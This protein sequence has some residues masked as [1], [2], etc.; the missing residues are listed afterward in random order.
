ME[1]GDKTRTDCTVVQVT[2]HAP[3]DSSLLW[4]GVR[5][6]TLRLN[7]A[8]DGRI[9]GLVYDRMREAKRKALAIVNAAND[10]QRLP[11]YEQL[12]QLAADTARRPSWGRCSWRQLRRT[13]AR[14]QRRAIKLRMEVELTARVIDQTQRRVLEGKKVPAP[15]E[16]AVAGGVAHRPDRQGPTGQL[17]RAQGVLDIGEVVA[18]VGLPGIAGQSS[19]RDL[20]GADDGAAPSSIWQGARSRP[21]LMERLRPRRI[22]IGSRRWASSRWR[23]ASGAGIPIQEMCDSRKYRRLGDF[24]R[25]PRDASRF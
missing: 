8:S 11:L 24:E 19:G 18:G 12:L 21:P 22:W 3:T 16:G 2:A 14:A 9:S 20:G 6:L 13:T 25:G 4:D 15:P 7:H 17:L 5:R 1:A 23:S 10:E